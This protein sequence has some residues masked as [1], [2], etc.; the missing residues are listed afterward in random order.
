MNVWFES[1]VRYQKL[2]EDGKEKS[3]TESYLFDSMS[4][5]EAEKRSIEELTPYI[6]GEM[7]IN[8][9]KRSGFSEVHLFDAGEFYFKARVAFVTIDEKTDKEK[10]QYIHMLVQ[11]DDLQQAK[12]RLVEKMKDT[13]ADYEIDKVAKTELCDVFPHMNK[14]VN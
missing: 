13:L 5:T 9:I 1:K 14:S 2:Q 3:V 4:F 12:D 11:A 7:S 6:S 10:R 8:A